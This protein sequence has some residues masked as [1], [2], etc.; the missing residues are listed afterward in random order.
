MLGD[1]ARE[2]AEAIDERVNAGAAGKAVTVTVERIERRPDRVP[3]GA[4][5]P[6]F[7]EHRVQISDGKRLASLDRGQ[8]E[9]LLDGLKPGCDANQVFEAIQSQDVPIEEAPQEI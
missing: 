3:G 2:F 1:E 8:V 5:R 4:G 6:T 7:I 9:L